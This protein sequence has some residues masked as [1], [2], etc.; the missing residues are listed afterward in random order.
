MGD[1]HGHAFHGE[2]LLVV[3]D[4]VRTFLPLTERNQQTLRWALAQLRE[5]RDDPIGFLLLNQDRSAHRPLAAFADILF[6]MSIPRGCDPTTTRRRGFVVRGR[7]PDLLKSGTA[8]LNAEGT[9]YLLPEGEGSEP[10]PPLLPILQELLSASA[11]PL[12]RKEILA[13]WPGPA[14]HLNSLWRT[15]ARGCQLDLFAWSGT[16]N[17]GEPYRY[18]LRRQAGQEPE[19][20]LPP[21]QPAGQESASTPQPPL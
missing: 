1:I 11:T 4:S 21:P 19:A 12:N 13:R 15:L 3:I 7:Y 20:A 6:E 14:P 2:P 9:D 18:S 10:A 17:K 16:G 5:F 8:E